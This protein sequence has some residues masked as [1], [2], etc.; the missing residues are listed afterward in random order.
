MRSSTTSERLIRHAERR[1]LVRPRDLN[2][3]GVSRTT[4][5]RLVDQGQL[6]R[7][8]RGLYVLPDH[9]P[10]EHTDLAGVAARVPHAIVCLLSALRF[11]GLTTQNPL[12]VWLMIDRKARR[13][14]LSEPRLRVVRASGTPLTQGVV[15]HRIEGVRVSITNPAKTVADCFRY[16][17]TIGTDVAIEALRDCR[18][19]K[20]ATI[21][22]LHRYAKIDHVASIMRPYLETLA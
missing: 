16:R 3:L 7:R 10:S 18:R 21:D 13:P 22:E 20:Q 1:G 2:S 19:Q 12:Q 6:V 8:A 17:R 15:H 11:H 14:A 4:F 9:E 5:Q